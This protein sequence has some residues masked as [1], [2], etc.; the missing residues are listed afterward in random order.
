MIYRL[1]WKICSYSVFTVWYCAANWIDIQL[2]LCLEDINK[3]K[4]LLLLVR[5]DGGWL[6]FKSCPAVRPRPPHWPINASLHPSRVG[7]LRPVVPQTIFTEGSLVLFSFFFNLFET[8][9]RAGELEIQTRKKYFILK[10]DVCAFHG[11]NGICLM[12]HYDRK[13]PVFII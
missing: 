8:H 13:Q 10:R 6:L 11:G 4:K 7:R 5:K 2:S 1:V 9:K 12:F 3:P